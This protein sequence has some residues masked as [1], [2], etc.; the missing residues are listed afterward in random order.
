MASGVAWRRDGGK[1]EHTIKGDREKNT[2]ERGKVKI[3]DLRLCVS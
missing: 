3:R 2:R 1:R